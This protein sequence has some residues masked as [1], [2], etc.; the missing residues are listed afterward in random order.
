MDSRGN[1]HTVS[2]DAR[3]APGLVPIPDKDLKRVKAMT[4]KQRKGWYR[5]QQLSRLHPAAQL[6]TETPEEHRA[7]RN[8]N[9]RA[10]RARR[11]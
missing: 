10:R 9:K 8:A 7:R 6:D 1:I 11:G 3:L 5:E 2:A 4:M